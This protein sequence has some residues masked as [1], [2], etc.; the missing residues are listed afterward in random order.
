MQAL[1]QGLRHHSS[2]H[3][4][5][6]AAATGGN[7]H[8]LHWNGGTKYNV[9]GFI[10]S[11]AFANVYKLSSKRDGAVFAVKELEKKRLA[12]EGPLSNKAFNELN[13]IKGLRHVSAATLKRKWQD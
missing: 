12:K 11:G 1:P 4:S 10:G 8:G 3:P 5:L 13:V 6:V 2:P 7:A 9:V